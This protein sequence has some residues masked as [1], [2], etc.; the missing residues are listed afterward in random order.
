[1]RIQCRVQHAAGRDEALNRILGRLPPAVEVVTDHE[2]KT[3][4]N[5]LRNYLRCLADIPNGATHVCVLQDDALPCAGFGM[6]MNDAVAER[7]HDVLSFF[8]GG[9]PGPSL[10][11]FRNAQMK[12]ERWA[13]LPRPT[14]IVHVVALVWPR[15]VAAE[16]LAWYEKEKDRIPHPQPHLSDDM[17]VSYW[18]KTAPSR[19]EVWA[20]VPCLVE[21]PD[22][23]VSVAQRRD[24]SG[25]KGRRAIAFADA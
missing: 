3:D 1:M 22:D 18:V 9:L 13:L 4:P 2:A 7:P 11:A 6:K 15:Q 8:V 24:K 21:H 25:D 10:K 23:L 12:G 5:P 19:P 17:V 16:F 20:T 14:K